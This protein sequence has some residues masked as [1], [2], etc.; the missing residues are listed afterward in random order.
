MVNGLSELEMV[1]RERKEEQTFA[2]NNGK[3]DKVTGHLYVAPLNELL[4]PE[5]RES[6]FD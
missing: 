3:N 4:D 5:T 6:C 2:N 1:I